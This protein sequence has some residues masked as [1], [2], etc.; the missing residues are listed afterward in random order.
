MV[1][2]T[3]VKGG[4]NTRYQIVIYGT[5]EAK[6][7]P[8]FNR[9][10]GAVYTPSRTQKWEYEVRQRAAEVVDTPLDGPVHLEMLF[11]FPRPKSKI[12]KRKKMEREWKTTRPDLDNLEKA[13]IDGLNGVAF[14][15]DGQIVWKCTKKMIADGKEQPRVEITI[16]QL[17]D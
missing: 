5:A 6:L 16:R 7:R 17:E 3:D 10:T 15:D 8:R 13:V 1:S 4:E 9:K 2:N 12:W 14:R 11:I